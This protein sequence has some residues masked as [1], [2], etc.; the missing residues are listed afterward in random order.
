[1]LKWVCFVQKMAKR[2]EKTHNFSHY[3]FHFSRFVAL[4][5]YQASSVLENA[6]LKDK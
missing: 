2:N 6:I 5:F 1:M 4:R 3:I